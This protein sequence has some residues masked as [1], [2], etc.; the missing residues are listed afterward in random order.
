MDSL[1]N[2]EI[3][4]LKKEDLDAIVRIDEKGSGENRKDYWER[5]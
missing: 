2:V 5:S 1:E 3:R 4:A